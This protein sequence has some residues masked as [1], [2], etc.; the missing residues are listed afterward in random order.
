VQAPYQEVYLLVEAR[1]ALVHFRPQTV[2]Q[3]DVMEL[4][5]KLM[6]KFKDNALLAG[7]GN[8]W[9]HSKMLGAGVALWAAEVSAKFVDDWISK[10]G[11]P[12]TFRADL[13]SFPTP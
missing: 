3:D 9:F 12:Q 5:K 2:S 7:Y 4:E 1:N 6:G 13:K 8:P 10:M 11:L